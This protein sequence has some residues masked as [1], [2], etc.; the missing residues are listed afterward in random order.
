VSE[1]TLD[2]YSED[3]QGNVWYFGEATA[4]FQNG[5]SVSTPG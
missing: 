5:V 1:D 4:E 3:R 2:Y